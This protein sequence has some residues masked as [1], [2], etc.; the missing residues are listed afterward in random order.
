[1]G[2]EPESQRQD[3]Q[4]DA[5]DGVVNGGIS[6]FA[7]ETADGGAQM[8]GVQESGQALDRG[9]WQETDTMYDN[10]PF[11]PAYRTSLQCKH[12]QPRY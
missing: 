9:M 2:G 5:P 12:S 6:Y 3:Q 7:E 1:M 4:G 11:D 8:E 10:L